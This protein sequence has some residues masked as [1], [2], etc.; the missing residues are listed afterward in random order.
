MSSQIEHEVIEHL[1][2]T[3]PHDRIDLKKAYLV[4]GPDIIGKFL[5]FIS[6]L[7]LNIDF[8]LDQFDLYMEASDVPKNWKSLPENLTY[9]SVFENWLKARFF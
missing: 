9:Y 3:T 1:F 7:G 8:S 6:E 5:N 2:Q 4:F